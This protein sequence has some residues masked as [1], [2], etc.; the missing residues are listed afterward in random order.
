[1]SLSLTIQPDFDK[2]VTRIFAIYHF[3]VPLSLPLA[4]VPVFSPECEIHKIYVNQSEIN[5]K[6]INSFN[7]RQQK[8]EEPNNIIDAQNFVYTQEAAREKF[9][10]FYIDL[11]ELTQQSDPVISLQSV[12]FLFSIKDQHALS[13]ESLNNTYTSFKQTKSQILRTND[14]NWLPIPLFFMSKYLKISA[15]FYISSKF[16]VLASGQRI[17]SNQFQNA[18]CTIHQYF[19]QVDQFKTSNKCRISPDHRLINFDAMRGLFD[20]LYEYITDEFQIPDSQ[21]LHWTLLFE[22]EFASE[23]PLIFQNIVIFPLIEFQ[24]SQDLSEYQSQRIYQLVGTAVSFCFAQFVIKHQTQQSLN[25]SLIT[26]ALVKLLL[27]RNCLPESVQI[28]QN[29]KT[30]LSFAKNCNAKM[31]PMFSIGSK[32]PLKLNQVAHD[33]KLQDV[34][35][36]QIN[37]CEFYKQ[38]VADEDALENEVDKLL[39]FADKLQRFDDAVQAAVVGVAQNNQAQSQAQAQAPVQGPLYITP[40][41]VF[42]SLENYPINSHQTSQN[43]R[44]RAKIAAIFLLNNCIDV[45]PLLTSQLSQVMTKAKFFQI[46]TQLSESSLDQQANGVG[47]NSDQ[48][49]NFLQKQKNS[50]LQ[51]NSDTLSQTTMGICQTFSAVILRT[52]QE[53]DWKMYHN[54]QYVDQKLLQNMKQNFYVYDGEQVKQLKILASELV[55]SEQKIISVDPNMKHPYC[56]WQR[57]NELAKPV[58]IKSEYKLLNYQTASYVFK[59][60]FLDNKTCYMLQLVKAPQSFDRQMLNL[61]LVAMYRWSSTFESSSYTNQIMDELKKIYVL[62]NIPS[63]AIQGKMQQFQ[64]EERYKL[65]TLLVSGKDFKVDDYK[66]ETLIQ[67]AI[68]YGFCKQNKNSLQFY[69]Q[70]I[71]CDK[72]RCSFNN[73]LTAAALQGLTWVICSEWAFDRQPHYKYYLQIIFEILNNELSNKV[74]V[75]NCMQLLSFTIAIS[76]YDDLYQL[77]IKL[78]KKKEFVKC[79]CKNC[80]QFADVYGVDAYQVLLTLLFE[81]QE[82][83]IISQLFKSQAITIDP[84]DSKINQTIDPQFLQLG[85]TASRYQWEH[86]AKEA[87]GPC[88]IEDWLIRDAYSGMYQLLLDRNVDLMT[89]RYDCQFCYAGGSCT[90]SLGYTASAFEPEDKEEIEMMDQDLLKSVYLNDKEPIINIVQIQEQQACFTGRAMRKCQVKMWLYNELITRLINSTDIQIKKQLLR[91]LSVIFGLQVYK[92]VTPQQVIKLHKHVKNVSEE[93]K[94]GYSMIYD[95]EWNN[96]F[97][98]GVGGQGFK[99]G[100]CSI[101]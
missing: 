63:E 1:M 101:E 86:L 17:S 21:R 67:A 77:F 84:L 52:Y 93:A 16:S 36:I 43:L 14:S 85:I 88:P 98:L 71:K 53:F 56:V 89:T 74:L 76:N 55:S 58:G 54:D 79:E 10:D 57:A 26:Q 30:Q 73:Q 38:S 97:L 20:R 18:Y 5:Q 48:F 28:Y 22:P 61:G 25:A 35:S 45:T 15:Q 95:E 72:K 96:Y 27:D 32:I 40:P 8:M 41:N 69:Q 23:D 91:A 9:G 24:Y 31:E 47:T 78:F 37:Q 12:S 66:T 2:K 7:F 19:F 29:Y 90:C 33:F 92:E 13:Y 65:F 64:P 80:A 68:L 34:C 49:C 39:V 3:D 83:Q 99:W 60:P 51:K 59:N 6:H 44:I 11:C 81:R 100:G 87:Q 62:G 82:Y 42:F 94:R 75:K 4:V 46:L 70:L 50:L